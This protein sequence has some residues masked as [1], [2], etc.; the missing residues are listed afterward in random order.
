MLRLLKYLKNYVWLI[1]I[2]VVLLGTQA[3]LQL[4]VPTA[5]GDIT[6]IVTHTGPYDPSVIFKNGWSCFFIQPTGDKLTDIWIAGLYMII[7]A[8]AA[9]ACAILCSN[10]VSFIGAKYASILRREVFKKVTSFSLGEFNKYGAASLITRTTNDIDQVKQT[11]MFTLRVMILSPVFIVIAISLIII[12]NAKLALI[13]AVTV[14]ILIILSVVLFVIVTPLF[15]NI[16]KA[17]DKVTQVLRESLTGVRVIR[18]FIQEESEA[19]RFG[20]ANANMT[21]MNKKTGRILSLMNPVISIIFDVTYLGIY[22]YGFTLINNTPTAV[23]NTTTLSSVIVCAQYAMQIMMS[24]M[25]FS[26]V[27]IMLPRASACAQRIN[28]VLNEK[29]LITNPENPCEIPEKKGY[30]EFKNVTFIFPDATLPTLMDISFKCE[31]GQTTAIIGSTGSGKSSIVNLIPRFYDISCGHIYVD[32]VDTRKYDLRQLRNK[33]GFVPQQALLFTGT[34]KDNLLYGNKDASE[35]ELNEALKVA[36]AY[37][38]VTRKENGINSDVAQGGKN[39][40]GGQKQRL[41]IARALVK[42]P[43]IYVFDDSFSA[44]DFKTDIKL[45]TAL[46]KYVGDSTTI[47]VAQRVATIMDADNII[48]LDDGKIVGQGTHNELLENCAV[49]QE[50]VYSQMDKDEIEK[51]ISMRKELQESK[52]GGIN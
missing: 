51:T 7:C 28:E 16:Q 47:I 27:F 18:A 31:P 15:K 21:T 48:V 24:F 22:F 44:L 33:I 20:V 8:F 29:P 37:E 4:M 32:G 36:Q 11:F 3:Y 12:E 14:P 17:I 30:I 13:L 40:S 49:Y 42:K 46:K 38:F 6:K 1:L 43:E 19:K 50:I 23:Y 26:M 35:E 9:F 52:E 34:I 45:R 39:F 10:S 2:I 5:M 25:M 41:S